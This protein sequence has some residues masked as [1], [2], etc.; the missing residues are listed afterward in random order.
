[1]DEQNLRSLPLNSPREELI[2]LLSLAVVRHQ[3]RMSEKNNQDTKPDWTLT[4]DRACMSVPSQP[5]TDHG[6]E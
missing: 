1:M 2:H 4:D 5:E 6:T 3:R